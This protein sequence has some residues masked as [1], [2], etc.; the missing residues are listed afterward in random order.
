MEMPGGLPMAERGDDRD[1]LRLDQLHVSLG[2]LLADWPAGLILDLTLQGDVLQHVEV[3]T[4]TSQHGEGSW[5]SRPWRRAI[6]GEPVTVGEAAR[7]RA[8]ADLDSLGRFLSVAGWADAAT[9]ARRLRDRLL[10]GG[11]VDAPV[12]GRFARVVDRS[13]VLAWSTRGLGVAADGD[14]VTVRYRRWLARV[15]EDVGRLADRTPLTP[16]VDAGRVAT[17][18]LLA[19]LPGLLEGVEL[20]AAR[21]IVASLDPDLDD[22]VTA[23][24][25][26]GRG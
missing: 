1:G 11:Q 9:T 17:A 23:E 16:T 18:D 15:V 3:R 26:V 25:A 8:A 21:L 12:V 6:A 5:W 2:P 10:A 19:L 20:A 4:R 24:L 14:D 7:W 13:R 22:L